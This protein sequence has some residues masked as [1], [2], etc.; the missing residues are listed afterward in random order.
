M[1]SVVILGAIAQNA[2]F[3]VTVPLYLAL[4]LAISPTVSAA[5]AMI[6]TDVSEVS[7]VPLSLILGYIVPAAM[8]S[9]PAPSMQSFEAKQTW[10][11]VW[12][13]F[14]LWVSVC[15]HVVKIILSSVF[16]VRQQST[17][18]SPAALRTTY[19]FLLILAGVTHIAAEALTATSMIFPSIFAAEYAEAIGFVNV[20][21]PAAITP[22]TKMPT[23]GSGA[24]MLLQYDEIVGSTA[25]LLWASFM[26]LR[27]RN[28]YITTTNW[29]Q[30]V[31]MFTLV[32]VL[33]G[34][35]GTAVALIWARDELVLKQK[36]N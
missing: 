15:Q 2:S 17:A 13:A 21:I 32:T 9:L 12:Q 31:V 18:D 29:L 3:A 34:P 25:M 10:I 8:L 26:Y 36:K 35:A 24:F 23:I 33:A 19:A 22:A 11:A 6:A 20:H 4:D 27:A 14:P 16:S 30:D 7:A 28:P 1:R 5:S